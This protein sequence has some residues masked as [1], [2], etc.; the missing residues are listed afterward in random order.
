MQ[1]SFSYDS[2]ATWHAFLSLHI[3]RLLA[4]NYQYILFQIGTLIYAR[5]VKAN[6]IMN[7]ELSCTDGTFF[8]HISQNVCLLYAQLEIY[9]DLY[10]NYFC[11][12]E[13]STLKNITFFF[14]S[15]AGGKA[16]EFGPLKDGYMFET[17]TGLARM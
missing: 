3:F 2:H 11:S 1:A 13:I 7:P 16:A 10:T 8:H 17:S 5:V 9:A 14:F 4:N 15:L 12:F 6:S